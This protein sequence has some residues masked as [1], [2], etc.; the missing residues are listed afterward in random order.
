[1]AKNF[2]RAQ[3]SAQKSRR[4]R[5]AYE[6]R[7]SAPSQF[8][9]WQE[10]PTRLRFD[11]GKFFAHDDAGAANFATQKNFHAERVFGRVEE[12]NEEKNA[13]ISAK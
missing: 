1:V 5:N 3:F 2:P 13:R 7:V 8:L 12:P 10:N 6:L 4:C 11:A 9:S